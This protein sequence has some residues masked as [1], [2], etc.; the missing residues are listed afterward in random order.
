MEKTVHSIQNISVRKDLAVLFLDEFDSNPA[1]YSFLLPILGD[2][3][4]YLYGEKLSLGKI[5]IFIAGSKQSV[6]DLVKDLSSCKC[7]NIGQNPVSVN[8][9]NLP[10]IP[11][12]PIIKRE[13]NKL[14]DLISR[15]N[16]GNF[17]IPKYDGDSITNNCDKVCIALF[18]IKNRFKDIKSIPLALLQLI[19]DT[20]L[21]FS[22]RSIEHIIYA[23][24]FSSF[25]YTTKT[26]Q[27]DKIKEF[28]SKKN[29]EGLSTKGIFTN[30]MIDKS[31]INHHNLAQ[32]YCEIMM[33]I[34]E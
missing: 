28:F 26:L 22:G 5:V 20:K 34:W 30:V 31:M 8:L 24:P 17:K 19:F 25:D 9:N 29:R 1:F 32:D 23:L 13:E 33:K 18:Q 15:V 4:A 6:R 3:D 10:D 2:G 11:N 16:G 7:D 21:R 27:T 14:P 12:T